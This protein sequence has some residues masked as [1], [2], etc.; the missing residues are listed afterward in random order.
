MKLPD[1]KERIDAYF[2]SVTPK[3]VV[4]RLEV[5][6]FEFSPYFAD[7]ERVHVE[8]EADDNVPDFYTLAGKQDIFI[9]ASLFEDSCS[10]KVEV[11]NEEI[12][13]VSPSYAM[14]A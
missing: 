14:A 3:V 10:F 8:Q 4:R 2:E 1:V 5:L 9:D 11:T 12:Q 7:N 13:S 6:G